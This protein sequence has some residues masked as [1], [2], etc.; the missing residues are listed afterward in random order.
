MQFTVN[1]QP[2]EPDA[3]V[4]V[5]TAF[6]V[7]SQVGAGAGAGVVVVAAAELVVGSEMI[8]VMVEVEMEIE[9]VDKPYAKV[10]L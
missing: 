3:V 10:V 6:P 9:E 5:K 4:S 2:H 8:G 1:W 7:A